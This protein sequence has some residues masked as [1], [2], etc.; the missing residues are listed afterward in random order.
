MTATKQLQA[1]LKKLHDFT[2]NQYAVYNDCLLPLLEENGINI[3]DISELG[4]KELDY[5][6]RYFDEVVFPVLTPMAVDS[7]RPFPLVR[8]RTV[9]I[10]ALI[11]KHG[12]ESRDFA[13][14]QVPGGLDRIVEIPTAE[15]RTFRSLRPDSSI[16]KPSGSRR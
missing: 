10:G 16:L 11:G 9:N 13:T 14:V 7:S 15:G 5:A 6:E 8:N 4:G 3:C 1:V 12:E 2:E